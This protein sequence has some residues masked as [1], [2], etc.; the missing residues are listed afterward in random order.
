MKPKKGE[1]L[2]AKIEI[3]QIIRD[4]WDQL[5]YDNSKHGFWWKGD[6]KSSTGLRVRIFYQNHVRDKRRVSYVSIKWLDEKGALGKF[7]IPDEIFT[8]LKGFKENNLR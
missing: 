3:A 6:F 4:H 1:T 7:L 2:K 5:N 8:L